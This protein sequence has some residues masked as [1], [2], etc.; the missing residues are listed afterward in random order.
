MGVQ[1]KAWMAQVNRLDPL[2]AFWESLP[3][4][5]RRQLSL[6][7]QTGNRLGIDL[8]TILQSLGNLART[9][10][11]SRG[12]KDAVDHYLNLR[13]SQNLRKSS[14]AQIC[15]NLNQMVS[16]FSPIRCDQISSS[17]IENW[18]LGNKWQRSTIDG[19]IAKIGPFFSWCVREG[20]CQINPCGAVKRPR[21]D[22][23]P[24]SIFHA[25]RDQKTPP[26]G[27]K[28]RPRTHPLPCYRP[29]LQACARLKLNAKDRYGETPLDLADGETA[30]LLRKHGGKTGAELKAEG[31]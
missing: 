10:P 13:A 11:K 17:M 5:D 22:D 6:I 26:S 15:L 30:N 19:V 29:L 28:L 24:P 7:H 18:F 8:N 23:S 9:K 20:Y 1:A 12:L 16:R 14:Y 31:K 27:P 21:R 3:D 4:D 25:T 2:L